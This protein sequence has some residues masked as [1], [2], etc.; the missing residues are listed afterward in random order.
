MPP[1]DASTGEVSNSQSPTQSPHSHPIES[2]IASPQTHI[3]DS[4]GTNNTMS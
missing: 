1:Q 4:E 2:L 3:N